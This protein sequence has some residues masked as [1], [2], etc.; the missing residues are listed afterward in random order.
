MN[1]NN[2]NNNEHVFHIDKLKRDFE[3]IISLKNEIIKTKAKVSERLGHLKTIYQELVKTNTKKII[4]FCL[5][6]FFFQYKSFLMEIDNIDRFRVIANNRMYCDYYKLYNIILT[7]IKEKKIE[8]NIDN[9]TSRD[10]PIYKDLEPYLEYKL[11]DIK[12]LHTNILSILNEMYNQ[13]TA[14][15]EAVDH[16]N[17]NHRIGFSISNFINTL[18][19]ENRLLRDQISLYINY[20]SFF[21]ISQ[22]K[23]LRRLSTK[24]NE[25]YKEIDENINDNRTFSIEDIEQEQSLDYFYNSGEDISIKNMIDDSSDFLE[26]SER[27]L[28]KVENYIDFNDST[29]QIEEL[30]TNITFQ[31]ADEVNVENNIINQNNETN[32]INS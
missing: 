2:N 10:Y 30:N 13:S 31:V 24:M 4:L 19:Y 28:N 7:D 16:Y 3:N 15:S 20:M 29:L 32:D 23:Q 9:I 12:D 8:I 1:N 6:S 26:S 27:I 22:K 25:F 5:D 17:D 14:K 21:H 11:D 18:Q